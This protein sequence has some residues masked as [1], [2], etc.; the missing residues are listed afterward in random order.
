MENS[1]SEQS[2]NEDHSSWIS[3][4]GRKEEVQ[5]K[6]IWRPDKMYCEGYS[7]SGLM[8]FRLFQTREIWED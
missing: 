4:Q 1:Q 2:E 6:D 8:F 5:R 7:M 3:I